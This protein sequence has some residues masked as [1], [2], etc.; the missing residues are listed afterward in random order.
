M[1]EEKTI[2]IKVPFPKENC[3][4]VKCPFH[5]KLKV[6]GR[7]FTG[8]VVSKDTHRSARVVWE[9]QYFIPK[10]E[11]S[12]RRLS[13]VSTH[14]PPCISAEIG[15]KVKI[16]ETKPISKTKHFVIIEKLEK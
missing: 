4:D 13:K 6:K 7:I 10:Y 9:R 12:E 5:G 8:K 3:K 1:K 15:D 2:G 16:I 11:R 14:N